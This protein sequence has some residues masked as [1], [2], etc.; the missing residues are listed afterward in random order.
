MFLISW[1]KMANY[2]INDNITAQGVEESPESTGV[3]EAKSSGNIA[4]GVAGAAAAVY[5]I[6]IA[7]VF[8]NSN[9]DTNVLIREL[10]A[11]KQGSDG[12]DGFM[13][14]WGY[15][16]I[17]LLMVLFL[18]VMGMSIFTY[19]GE[20]GF[21]Q[22]SEGSARVVL[23]VIGALVCIVGLYGLYAGMVTMTIAIFAILALMSSVY[24][25]Y[26]TYKK[27]T[28]NFD[29]LADYAMVVASA[30]AALLSLLFAV[31]FGTAAISGDSSSGTVSNGI[32]RNSY[33]EDAAKNLTFVH[34]AAGNL[35]AVS[36]TIMTNVGALPL[37]ATADAKA[38][39]FDLSKVYYSG[40]SSVTGFKN[41]RFD[42]TVRLGTSDLSD[43]K[44]VVESENN[45]IFV[46]ETIP[47]LTVVSKYGGN[48]S[49]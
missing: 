25:V 48:I 38:V 30:V 15:T 14:D 46:T 28:G 29:G 43:R 4:M 2:N 33:D 16:N 1:L 37:S 34:D 42:A 40:N 5:A 45:R 12:F 47:N 21:V 17:G 26:M 22:N 9:A 7:Y 8:L 35:T 24:M 3:L 44:I 39:K 31:L 10:L 20:S 23:G 18:V 41:F 36:G 11:S 27:A 49:L 6:A 13:F 32:I 19:I